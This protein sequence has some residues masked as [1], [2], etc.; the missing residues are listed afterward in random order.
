MRET[1]I[2]NPAEDVTSKILYILARHSRHDY[3]SGLRLIAFLD[4][5]IERLGL[6]SHIFLRIDVIVGIL[7]R[8]YDKVSVTARNERE[9]V[10]L[11]AR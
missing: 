4:R 3:R 9:F 5:D 6:E 11:A 7:Y 10:C 2:Q 1:A 8:F